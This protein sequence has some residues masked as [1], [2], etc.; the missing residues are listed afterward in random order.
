MDSLETN[1]SMAKKR[2]GLRK[3][4]TTTTNK[5]ISS[6]PQRVCVVKNVIEQTIK[7]KDRQTTYLFCDSKCVFTVNVL[8]KQSRKGKHSAPMESMALPQNE[9]L[10]IVGVLKEYLRRT[11]EIRE[12]ENKPLLS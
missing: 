5:K 9:K 1:H 12:E 2:A 4:K 10:C 11:K 6:P 3:V 7:N 8:L